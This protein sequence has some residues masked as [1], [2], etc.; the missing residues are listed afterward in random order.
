MKNAYTIDLRGFEG[1]MNLMTA[2]V[3]TVLQLL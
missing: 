3:G 2:A 1:E